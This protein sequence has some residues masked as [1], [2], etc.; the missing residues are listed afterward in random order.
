MNILYITNK[1]I[2]PIVDGGCFAMDAFLRSLLTFAS[3]KNITIET[4]KHPFQIA[5]FPPDIKSLVN[6]EGHL[7]DTKFRFFQCISSVITNKSY[8]VIRFYKQAFLKK[9]FEEL[10]HQKYDCIVLESSYLLV[11]TKEIKRNF[12]G[13]I[14]LRAPNVEYKIWEDYAK[15]SN[16]FIQRTAYTFLAKRLKKFEI[17][18][19]KQVDNIFAITEND[20]LQFIKDGN[21]FV[22]VIPVGIVSK[23]Q[24]IPQ[25]NVNK[26]FFLG[27]FNWKPN[28]DA[29]FYLIQE[30]LPELQ[31]RFPT[32]ELHLAGSYMPKTIYELAN[33]NV[34]IHGKVKSSEEFIQNNG[35]LVAPIFSG[36]GVR[37]KILEALSF[38]LPVVASTIAMQGIPSKSVLIADNKKEFIE[39]ISLLLSQKEILKNIQQKGLETIK[40]EFSNEQISFSLKHLLNA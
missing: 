27:A 20:K 36:S 14:I 33:T 1:P 24:D 28:L 12:K 23:V 19:S 38:G 31:R 7:I 26:I 25:I 39:Q 30:I 9:I 16:S 8:N 15:F 34:I 2:Y 18:A 17:K 3:V 11:Y 37:I 21:K 4:H 35:I 10:N 32:I 5:Q 40:T 22:E 29:A 6:P 13:K